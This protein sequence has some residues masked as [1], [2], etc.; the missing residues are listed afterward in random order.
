MTNGLLFKKTDG[1]Y[2]KITKDVLK[3]IEK[4]KQHGKDSNE[5]GGVLVGRFIS[6][7]NNIVIDYVSTPMKDDIRQRRFFNRERKEHQAFI[8]KYWD[9]SIGTFNY[10]GEWHTHPESIPQPSYVDT[11]EWK[12]ILKEAKYEGDYLLFCIVGLDSIKLWQGITSSMELRQ[13]EIVK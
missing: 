4:Y 11:G 12:R 10:I 13:L 5:A 1:G 7:S 6:N 9:E 2:V 8:D 3:I